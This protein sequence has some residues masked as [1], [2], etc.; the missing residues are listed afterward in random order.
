MSSLIQQKNPVESWLATLPEY[1]RSVVLG[2]VREER[3]LVLSYLYASLLG[4]EAPI[5]EW[6]A[7]TTR[8][9]KKLDH[10][11]ILET[12]IVE[13][14][15]D[16]GNIRQMVE[17]GTM[18]AGDAPTKISYLSKELRGHIEHLSKEISSHDRGTLLLAG[19]EIASKALRKVFGKDGS[20]WPAVE[21]AMES[22]WAEI[23]AK[24]CLK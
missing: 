15:K 13:L 23:E 8:H 5:D 7:W 10:R 24:H 20:V 3:S 17:D 1:R 22:A 19:V 2:Y 4:L 11:A 21:A 18:R 9:F 16:I 6:E 14:H 12:E